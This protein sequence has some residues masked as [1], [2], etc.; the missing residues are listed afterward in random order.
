MS[1]S[2]REIAQALLDSIGGKQ[3]VTGLKRCST[4]LRF[5]LKN[6]SLVREENIKRLNG[7]IGIIEADNLYYIIPEAGLTLKIYNELVHMVDSTSATQEKT[8]WFDRI[9]N[10]FQGER[11]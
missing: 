1:L 7:I 3:N 4:K 9:R 10:R 2:A 5:T 8:R 11:K 6:A